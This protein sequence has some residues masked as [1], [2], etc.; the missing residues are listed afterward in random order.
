VEKPARIK[1]TLTGKNR[2]LLLTLCVITGILALVDDFQGWRFLFLAL[3]GIWWL[4]YRWAKSLTNKL[5]L[6]REMRF[7][8]AQVGDWL[9]ERYSLSNQSHFPAVWVELVDQSNLP[10]YK[11]D[12]ATGIDGGASFQWRTRSLCTQRGLFTLGPT[13]LRSADPLGLYKIEIHDPRSFTL[14]ITPPIVPL[15]EIEV[16]PGG[17]VGEGRPRPNAPERTVS[18][19]GVRQ[20]IPSDSLRDIHWRTSARRD[21][22]FVRL[23]DSTPSGD[24]WIILDMDR[25]VQAGSGARSTIEHRVILA[26]SLADRGLRMGRAVGVIAHG[27]PLVWLTPLEGEVQRWQILRALALVEPAA[28]P[29]AELLV[30]LRPTLG[31]Y[32]SLVLITPNGSSEWLKG[33]LPLIWLGAV[34]TVLLLDPVTF[35]EQA[36]GVANPAGLLH[37]FS[38]WGIHHHLITPDLLDRPEASPGHKGEWQW[39]IS[40]TGRAVALNPAMDAAWRDIQ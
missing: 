17:K 39:R 19:S 3:G 38:R 13:T 5:N 23:F 33:L 30:S 29:L 10:G 40:P 34:P 21:D 22:L 1:A 28:Y 36:A 20:Y 35:A 8:W 25:T 2:L 15:P 31:G 4:S 7:G 12:I 27:K 16:A 9:E 14:M 11:A 26:A 32:T 6:K 24:W 18:A 37:E